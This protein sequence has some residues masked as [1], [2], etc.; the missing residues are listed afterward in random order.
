MAVHAHPDD[1]SSS[2]GGVLAKYSE[3]GIRTVVVTCTNG[4]LG[5][6]PGGVKPGEEG[7]DDAAV[8]RVRLA[9][10]DEACEILGVD[11]VELLGYRDSGMHGWD[12][13]GR[14]DAFCNIP[15]DQSAVLL[16]EIIDR[17]R[18]SVIVTYAENGGYGH[19]DHVQTHRVTLAAIE[20][21]GWPA[22]LYYTARPRSASPPSRRSRSRSESARAPRSSVS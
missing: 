7:H 11:H 21:S 18:P 9:E 1:E 14:P 22:K 5:D 17:Y 6:G 2:T 16:A 13:N 20:R 3:E 15:L 19:P 12:G 4:E 8:A 10:L